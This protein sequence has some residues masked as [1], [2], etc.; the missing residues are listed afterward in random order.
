MD[1]MGRWGVG[2]RDRPFREGIGVT[3][4]LC[5]T[6]VQHELNEILVEDVVR[7]FETVVSTSDLTKYAVMGGWYVGW[8]AGK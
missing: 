3:G 5:K 2:A 7:L 6:I 8:G 4:G 1:V